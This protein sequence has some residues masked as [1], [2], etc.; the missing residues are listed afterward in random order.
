M[1]ASKNTTPHSNKHI[2]F[3]IYLFENVEI[4]TVYTITIQCYNALNG[5]IKFEMKRNV[6][7]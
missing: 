5:L 2:S 3:D 1:F 6:K 7:R 4:L